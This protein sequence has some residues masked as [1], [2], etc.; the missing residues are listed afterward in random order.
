MKTSSKPLRISSSERIVHPLLKWSLSAKAIEK[1]AKK[2]ARSRKLLLKL[3]LKKRMTIK[4]KLRIRKLIPRRRPKKKVR[5]KKRRR[6]LRKNRSLKPLPRIRK[7]KNLK[8]RKSKNLSTIRKSIIIIKNII[9]TTIKRRKNLRMKTWV[10]LR[11][12]FNKR[13]NKSRLTTL[14]SI[15]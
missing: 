1:T 11:I 7:K 14:I 12:M 5:R 9:I 6:N 3:R 2:R 13:G 8:I 4:K 10:L 15:S